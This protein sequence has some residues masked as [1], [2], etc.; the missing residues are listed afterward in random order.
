[1][2]NCSYFYVPYQRGTVYVRLS[3]CDTVYAQWGMSVSVT[4]FDIDETR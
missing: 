1:M 3:L 2:N 4:T